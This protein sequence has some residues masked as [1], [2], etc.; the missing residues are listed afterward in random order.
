MSKGSIGR[1]AL[2]RN[3]VA[4]A[5]W[6]RFRDYRARIY[7][8]RNPPKAWRRDALIEPIHG[9]KRQSRAYQSLEQGDAAIRNP[10]I[11]IAGIILLCITWWRIS[12]ALFIGDSGYCFAGHRIE[13]NKP[14]FFQ[15]VVYFLN[16]RPYLDR[17]ELKD[18]ILGASHQSTPA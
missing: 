11:I 2:N 17:Q 9:A 10:N 16:D 13:G 8:F 14:A 18:A 15:G 1:L 3:L 4:S 6:R 5:M 12:L 7:L